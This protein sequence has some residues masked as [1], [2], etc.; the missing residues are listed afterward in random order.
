[1]FFLKVGMKWFELKQYQL[2]LKGASTNTVKASHSG[3]GLAGT[4]GLMDS[5]E[6][7]EVPEGTYL[8]LQED[9]GSLPLY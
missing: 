7:R 2:R 8:Q 5:T 1:M 3:Q 4:N 9:I 6:M